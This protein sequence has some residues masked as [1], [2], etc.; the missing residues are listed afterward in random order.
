MIHKGK[1]VKRILKF[2]QDY[3][4]DQV[5]R[6]IIKQK[7]KEDNFITESKYWELV[8]G[9]ALELTNGIVVKSRKLEDILGELSN[10]LK[11]YK[12]VFEH[13]KKTIAMIK[14][15]IQLNAKILIIKSMRGNNNALVVGKFRILT[16]GGHAKLIRKAITIYDD[17]VICIVSSKDTKEMK[18]IREKMIMKTF[19][20][21]NIIHA[22]NGN[23]IRIF[24]KSPININVVC[25][26]SDRVSG[27]R[28]QLKNNIGISVKETLRSINDI[29]ATSVINNINDES[30]FKRNTPKEIHS[31][32]NRLKE[33]YSTKSML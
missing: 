11:R 30:F 10:I 7:Y 8:K 13:S 32:Y 2:V 17:V 29:S 4:V 5:Q 22:I 24:N 14:D 9:A 28:D 1:K 33:V 26:G 18:Y 25:A 27:Y 6:A 12:I 15:D 20:G 19:P 3:Q 31:M 23:L 21:V 16:K